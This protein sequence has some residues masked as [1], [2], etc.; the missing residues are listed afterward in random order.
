MT[1]RIIP[2]PGNPF[3]KVFKLRCDLCP[4]YKVDPC[5]YDDAVD[6]RVRHEGLHQA[7]DGAAVVAAIGREDES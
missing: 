1:V 5:V 7:A 4:D 3:R 6:E 2:L